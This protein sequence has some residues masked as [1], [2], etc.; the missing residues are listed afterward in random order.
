MSPIPPPAP[1]L[2][3]LYKPKHWE[4][5]SPQWRRYEEALLYIPDIC[6]RLLNE[7]A[8]RRS[9]LC[10]PAARPMTDDC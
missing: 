9:A 10:P 6:P 4:G 3:P 1:P 5:K 7:G 2:Q 8:L